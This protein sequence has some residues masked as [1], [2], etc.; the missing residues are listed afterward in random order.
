[1]NHLTHPIVVE[2]ME[3]ANKIFYA[4]VQSDFEPGYHPEHYAAIHFFG[5]DYD[6]NVRYILKF[7]SASLEKYWENLKK[8]LPLRKLVNFNFDT[9]Q[10]GN[11]CWW[12]Y[13]ENCILREDSAK[14]IQAYANV[15][16]KIS[17]FGYCRFAFKAYE[18]NVR[19]TRTIL[20][21]DKL[22]NQSFN[23]DDVIDP[24]LY[25][26]LLRWVNLCEEK[27]RATDIIESANKFLA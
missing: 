23:V 5:D 13:G 10:H 7:E 6:R 12:G 4:P 15:A 22:T 11:L 1:M 27:V 19:C 14:E 18:D 9:G 17:K 26:D 20:V 24:N 16:E 8:S 3:D 21:T 2:T 25:D